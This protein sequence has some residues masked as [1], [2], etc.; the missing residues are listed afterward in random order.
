MS[1]KLPRSSDL[2]LPV[3]CI[4]CRPDDPN[5][6]TVITRSRRWYARWDNFPA[7]PGHLELA[8]FRHIPSFFDLTSPEMHDLR[9]VARSARQ[10]LHDQFQPDGY[11]HR[12]Q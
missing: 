10:L 9:A 6:N 11:H 5:L 7:Q 12:N 1:S 8:P 3:S 2:I 4:F